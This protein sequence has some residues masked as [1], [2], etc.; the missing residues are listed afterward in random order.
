[1]TSFRSPAKQA[2]FIVNNLRAEKI[3]PSIRSANNYTERLRIIAQN[4]RE[5]GLPNLRELSVLQCKNYL[6]QR[7]QEVS[8][9]TLDSERLALQY[10]M[11]LTGQLS[12][13]QDEKLVRVKSELDE[14]KRSRFY[15]QEQKDLV[16]NCQTEKHRLITEIASATGMRAHEILTM[17][18]RNER[19]PDKR[20]TN[21]EK[22]LGRKGNLFTTQGKGSLIREVMIPTEL[23]LALQRYRLGEPVRVVDRGVVYW[24]HYDLPGGHKWSDSF[25]KASN[26]TLG[27]SRGAHG[28]RHTYAQERMRELQSHGVTY[29]LALETV[30]QEMG[31]FRAD[32]TLV[33]L[34]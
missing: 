12:K 28:L 30:S 15:T 9:S 10:T 26:R 7:G 6:E 22:F 1:M 34:R 18:P 3:I 19:E 14:A 17:L 33:Y 13:E 25:S 27:W 2:R 29:N 11:Q 23:A 21:V 4:C 20:P 5:W 31:H 16:K 8:Q 24:S 32:I